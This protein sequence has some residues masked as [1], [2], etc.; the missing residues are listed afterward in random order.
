VGCWAETFTGGCALRNNTNTPKVRTS[1]NVVWKSRL[2]GHL[3]WKKIAKVII[4]EIMDKRI[5]Y[6]SVTPRDFA[7]GL[8]A[9]FNRGNLRTQVLGDK[10]NL[11]VQI[12]SQPGAASGGQTALTVLLQAVEDG[13]MVQVGQQTWMGVAASL[14]QSALATALNPWNLLNRLDD[15]AQDIE[16]LQIVENVWKIIEKVAQVYGASQQLSERLRR[17]E[18]GYCGAAN[19]VGA[20]SCLACGAPLGSSQPRTCRHCGFL[21]NAEE[22]VCPQCGRVI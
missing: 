16:N 12:A 1:Q 3:S 2:I 6:G 13:V 20:S 18:C 15:I 8:A 7:E 5:F 19:P 22:P 10:D 14:G 4:I 11:K 9:Q 17:L 21:L